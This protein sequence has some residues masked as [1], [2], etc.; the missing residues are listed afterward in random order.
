MRAARM[1][2]TAKF[3]TAAECRRQRRLWNHWGWL[4]GVRK[5]NGEQVLVVASCEDKKALSNYCLRWQIET[6]FGVLKTRGFR[7]ED[8]HLTETDRA[9]RL[10]SL[11]AIAF[12]WAMLSGEFNY[13]LTPYI[14]S[15]AITKST[16]SLKISAPFYLFY[17]SINFCG[18]TARQV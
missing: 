10:L 14:F 3:E 5:A 15:S 17:F 13:N 1:L 8:T 18:F 12:Y 2:R 11:L 4:S 6:L 7:L 16:N 9:A